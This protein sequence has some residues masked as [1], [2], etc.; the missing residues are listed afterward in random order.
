MFTVQNMSKPY[1]SKLLS[2]APVAVFLV[3]A[4]TLIIIDHNQGRAYFDHTHFHL[5]V[6]KQLIENFDIS[7]YKAATAPGYHLIFAV[8]GQLTGLN[9]TLFK[10]VNALIT[11]L[12]IGYLSVKLSVNRPPLQVLLLMLPMVLSVYILPSGIWLLPDN[13]A[14][15]ALAWLIFQ[16]KH[17]PF[18][19]KQ[20]LCIAIVLAL[21]VLV[22][23]TY[24]WLV[25]I[26]WASGI[27]VYIKL[28]MNNKQLTNKIDDSYKNS[29][30][31][32]SALTYFLKCLLTT[33]P[34]F[35]VLAYLAITW[36]GLVPPSFQSIH[37]HISPSAPAFFFALFGVYTTFYIPFFY[38]Q[39]KNNITIISIIIGAI[40]GFL[41]VIF[42]DSS[43]DVKAG[44]FGGLWNIIK[45]APSIGDKSLLMVMLSTLGG[46]VFIVLLRL[47]NHK[48]RLIILIACIAFV[49]AMTVNQF[50]YERY[51]SGFIYIILTWLV[52]Q[53]TISKESRSAKTDYWLYSGV[54]IFALLNALILYRSLNQS[55]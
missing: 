15:F 40:V 21:A 33:L 20:L 17:S 35:L 3:I 4:F 5:P 52:S 48:E 39:I 28:I 27:S 26:I 23:Q 11:S 54:L 24:L 41:S 43:Y 30:N 18:D 7:D 34:A 1:T 32:N 44:R 37:H 42:I 16:I 8:I 22:R 13:L 9:V 46:A 2:L 25:S 10:L 47:L 6:I 31:T 49:S 51:F 45:I 38:R 55:L 50:V 36:Q 53:Q 19:N 12:F 14:W 29:Q